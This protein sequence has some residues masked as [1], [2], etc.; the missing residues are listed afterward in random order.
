MLFEIIC[1]F[2]VVEVIGFWYGYQVWKEGRKRFARQ[3][4]QA[5][6]AAPVCYVMLVLVIGLAP[7]PR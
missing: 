3:I 2:V 4:V 6:V 5:L 7:M 1:S